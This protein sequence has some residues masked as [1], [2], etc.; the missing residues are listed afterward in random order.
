MESNE[1]QRPF[2]LINLFI[3][4]VSNISLTLQESMVRTVQVNGTDAAVKD[5]TIEQDGHRVV[6]TLWRQ[7]AS[8]EDV[9]NG[10][11]LEVE[12]VIVRQY[13][14]K[15]VVATTSRSSITVSNTQ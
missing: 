4:V 15:N 8:N 9:A 10:N 11:Y 12:N 3:H 7:Y 1:I 14:G 2:R 13:N 5:I 6:L